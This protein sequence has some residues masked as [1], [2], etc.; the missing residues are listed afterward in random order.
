MNVIVECMEWGSS[1]Y[2][3]GLELRDRVLRRPL[4]LSIHDDPTDQEVEDYHIRAVAHGRTVGVLLLKRLDD[5]RLQMKQ[6]A[7]DSAVQGQAIGRKMVVF[8]EQMALEQGFS[9]IM[10]HGRLTAVP[11]YEKLGYMTEGDLFM[12]VGIPHYPMIKALNGKDM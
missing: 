3:Q 11:F 5:S 12:E 9:K 4:G 2:A 7:V 1:A 10:L 8:A 6:V